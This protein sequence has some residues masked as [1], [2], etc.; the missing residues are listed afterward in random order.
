VQRDGEACECVEKQVGI[1]RRVSVAK[2]CGARERFFCLLT[3]H[4]VATK[5]FNRK[6]GNLAKRQDASMHTVGY[7]IYVQ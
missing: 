6:A 2:R 1:E 3:L 7:Y 5:T 4:T